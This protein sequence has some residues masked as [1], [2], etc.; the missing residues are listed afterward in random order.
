M[1]EAG[2]VAVADAD[3]GVRIRAFLSLAG[4]SKPSLIAMKRFCTEV[5]PVYM[6]PDFFAFLEELPKTS[7]DKIDYQTLKGLP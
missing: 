6:V 1:K 5:L 2:V 7:T 3:E 4:G